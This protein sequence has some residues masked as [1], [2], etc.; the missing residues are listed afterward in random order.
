MSLFTL[1]VEVDPLI[2]VLRKHF[3]MVSNEEQHVWA[4]NC[5]LVFALHV[6]I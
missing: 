1:W 3:N 5:I 2:V 4:R 6:H